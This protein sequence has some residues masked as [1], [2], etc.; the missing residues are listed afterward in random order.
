[1]LLAVTLGHLRPELMAVSAEVEA[2]RGTGETG[3]PVLVMVRAVREERRATTAAPEEREERPVGLLR[4]REAQARSL[5]HHMAAAEGAEVAPMRL[6]TAG[7]GAME[8]NTAA[9]EAREPAIRQPTRTVVR[10]SSS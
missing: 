9:A 5:M 6:G 10:A 2:V 7:R 4:L 1:M 3:L 8:G